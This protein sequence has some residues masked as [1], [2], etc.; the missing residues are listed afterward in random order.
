MLFVFFLCHVHPMLPV[1]LDCPFLIATSVSSSNVYL[2]CSSM[3]ID[4]FNM[5]FRWGFFCVIFLSADLYR[6]CWLH[7]VGLFKRR[8]TSSSQKP[9]IQWNQVGLRGSLRGPLSRLCPTSLCSIQDGHLKI[10]ISHFKCS[11]LSLSWMKI[12][13]AK[14]LFFTDYNF[15]C[16]WFT[17]I[18]A[19]I[20]FLWS[21]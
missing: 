5:S 20:I 2:H 9:L 16:F 8:Q 1:S 21:F 17:D 15:H 3:A 13:T 14:V 19:G 12:S 6:L 4:L 11:N 7:F 18:F 10:D